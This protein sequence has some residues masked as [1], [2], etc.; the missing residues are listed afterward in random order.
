M[1]MMVDFLMVWFQNKSRVT[2]DGPEGW[3]KG[4]V[5]NERGHHQRLKRQQGG[6]RGG[7]VLAGIIEGI[8]AGPWKVPDR[9]KMT[10]DA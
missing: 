4:W 5:K 1:N 9:T 2:L 8:S 10:P 7:V 6:K 3:S